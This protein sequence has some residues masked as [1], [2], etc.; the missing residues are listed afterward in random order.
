MSSLGLEQQHKGNK[1]RIDIVSGLSASIRQTSLAGTQPT[2]FILC[3]VSAPR[4]Y[5]RSGEKAARRVR[6]SCSIAL[7][8]S[9]CLPDT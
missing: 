6:A 5:S 7:Y 8:A 3:S 1:Y 4:K 9:D 2:C